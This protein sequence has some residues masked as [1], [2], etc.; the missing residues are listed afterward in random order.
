MR[1]PV[2]SI[3]DCPVN[4]RQNLTLANKLGDMVAQL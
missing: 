4:Y 3:I 2:V 1:R